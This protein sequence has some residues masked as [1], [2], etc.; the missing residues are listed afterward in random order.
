MYRPPSHFMSIFHFSCVDCSSVASRSK[1]DEILMN[2][3]RFRDMYSK[4][5]IRTGSTR[6]K[7]DFDRNLLQV[8]IQSP[9]RGYKKIGPTLKIDILMHNWTPKTTFSMR[10]TQYVYIIIGKIEKIKN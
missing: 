5:G 3:Y 1:N 8:L 2:C 10:Y 6:N 4:P 9:V 7:S